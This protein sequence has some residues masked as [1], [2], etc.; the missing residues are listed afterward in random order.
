[1]LLLL[2]LQIPPATWMAQF[3]AACVARGLAGATPQE[4]CMMLQGVVALKLQ[5][6]SQWVAA[7]QQSVLQQLDQ[8]GARDITQVWYMLGGSGERKP[9]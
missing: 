2:L 8:L 4:L 6:G 5:P 7:L 3:E 1:M 9:G